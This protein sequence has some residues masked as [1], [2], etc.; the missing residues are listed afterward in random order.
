MVVPH[1]VTEGEDGWLWQLSL[2]LASVQCF[3]C[4]AGKRLEVYKMPESGSG[5][6]SAYCKLIS[7]SDVCWRCWEQDFAAQLLSLCSPLGGWEGN[8]GA[9]QRVKQAATSTTW[10]SIEVFNLKEKNTHHKLMYLEGHLPAHRRGEWHV[11]HQVCHWSIS[12]G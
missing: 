8:C 9:K 3:I 11:K 5:N 10:Y 6:I 4:T 7:S 1:M 2:F 12:C